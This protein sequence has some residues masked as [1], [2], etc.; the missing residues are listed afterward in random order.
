MKKITFLLLCF[1]ANVSAWADPCPESALTDALGTFA[2]Q[3]SP[4][5]P[6]ISEPFYV[7]I[8]MCD[9]EANT[10][11]ESINAWMP[12]HNHGMNYTPQL[13]SVEASTTT[14]EGFLFHM[15]GR[16]QFKLTVRNN[17]ERSIL[18]WDRQITP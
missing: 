9:A 14:F 12:D 15:P 3:T 1:F 4:E 13:I 16:W 7:H 18:R 17:N 10:D 6:A 5:K 8:V 2:L 11:I